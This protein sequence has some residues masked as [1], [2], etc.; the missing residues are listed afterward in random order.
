MIRVLLT[1]M[2]GTG[3]STVVRELAARGYRAMDVDDPGLGL[4]E[5]RGHGVWGWRIDR[6]QALLSDETADV[7]FV[8]GCADEQVQFHPHFDHVILLSAP[9]AVVVE[10]LRTRTGNSYGKEPEELRRVLGHIDTV[11]PLLRNLAD[12]EVDTTEPLD[13]VVERIISFVSP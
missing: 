2:S 10:R 5:P 7:L 8:A 12:L 9:S 13:E 4:S 11:E 6:V 1:G 3:K